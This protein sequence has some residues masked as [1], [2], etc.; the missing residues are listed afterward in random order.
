MPAQQYD[1][2]QKSLIK[3][4]PSFGNLGLVNQCLLPQCASSQYK[5][6]VTTGKCN[7]PECLNIVSFNND[8]SFNNSSVVIK[9]SGNCANI[10]GPTPSPP[11]PTPSPLGPTPSPPCPPGPSGPSGP[12]NFFYNHEYL[13]IGIGAAVLV[14]IVIIIILIIIKRRNGKIMK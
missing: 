2:F 6:V 12:S 10:V 3:L 11:G 9:Q 1:N 14:I 4:Y 7:L 13:I 5:S 8:G